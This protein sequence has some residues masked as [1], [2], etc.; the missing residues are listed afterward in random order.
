M[1]KSLPFIIKYQGSYLLVYS[2]VDQVVVNQEWLLLLQMLYLFVYSL[3]RMAHFVAFANPGSI[4]NLTV[5]HVSPVLAVRRSV[6]T[7]GNA[8]KADVCAQ[9]ALKALTVSW[10]RTNVRSQPPRTA[11]TTSATTRSAPTNASAHPT[12]AV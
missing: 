1:Y 2:S 12:I 10:T 7:V 5:V 9:P 4:F 3:F 11:A 8:I 6:R